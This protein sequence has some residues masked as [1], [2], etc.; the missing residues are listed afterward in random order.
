MGNGVQPGS[1]PIAL[2]LQQEEKQIQTTVRSGSCWLEEVEAEALSPGAQLVLPAP[3]WPQSAVNQMA[4]HCKIHSAAKMCD[5]DNH[6][7]PRTS[8]GG[9]RSALGPDVLNLLYFLLP[10]ARRV[11]RAPHFTTA[12]V[13]PELGQGSCRCWEV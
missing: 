5:S 2:C 6:C 11:Q 1:E 12:G 9:L 4:C 3:P 13:C 8:H 10:L 7:H